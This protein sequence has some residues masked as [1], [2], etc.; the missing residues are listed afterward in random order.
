MKYGKVNVDVD[1]ASEY[2]YNEHVYGKKEL[3]IL[4]SIFGMFFIKKDKPIPKASIVIRPVSVHEQPTP[5][6]N[7]RFVFV[8]QRFE[9][10][11]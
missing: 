5:A 6:L 9:E 1:I 2:R 4:I 10:C 11:H 3:I 8:D 7:I